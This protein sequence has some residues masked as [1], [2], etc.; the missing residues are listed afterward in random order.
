MS[1]TPS[2]PWSARFSLGRWTNKEQGLPKKKIE[3]I[4]RKHPRRTAGGDRTGR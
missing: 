1:T 3:R 4:L 2:R